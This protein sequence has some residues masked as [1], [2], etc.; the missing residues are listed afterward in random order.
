M[1]PV[2]F[3][4]YDER[5]LLAYKVCCASLR[6]HT[7]GVIIQPI[8]RLLLGA[9]Y[10]RPTERRE[11]VLWDLISDAP[12]TTDFSLARFFVPFLAQAGQA[13]FCDCD[14]LWRGS[15]EP[16]FDMAA[17]SPHHALLCVKHEHAQMEG[18]KMD[19]QPQT[20]YPRK[21]WSSMV[22]W[23]LDHPSNKPL[24]DSSHEANTLK[25]SQLHR[26]T[27]LDDAE[28][29]GLPL[30]WNW[31]EGVSPA[32]PDPIAVHFTRGTPNLP[33]YEGSQFASEWRD[34]ALRAS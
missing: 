18:V 24:V 2:V 31:L 20:V 33:G 19:R 17:G 21:N 3:V 12:C 8:S 7:P 15:I 13:A 29:G 1:R 23:N 27:W 25:G 5:E 34:Y 32:C 6:A 10:Q 30:G 16:L 14:F 28:I 9:L 26:F 22:V 4:G 11:R